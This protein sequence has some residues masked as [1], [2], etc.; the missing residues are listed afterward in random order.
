MSISRNIL[1]LVGY[2]SNPTFPDPIESKEYQ[3]GIVLAP[4]FE[5]GWRMPS[6][7]MTSHGRDRAAH[8]FLTGYYVGRTIAVPVNENRMRPRPTPSIVP[9]VTLDRLLLQQATQTKLEEN[10][11]KAVLLITSSL[12][13][14]AYIMA[15]PLYGLAVLPLVMISLL[16]IRIVRRVSGEIERLWSESVA[17]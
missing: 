8:F 5:T 4:H 7:K 16:S 17:E 10:A 2:Q 6:A 12:A 9:E 15:G 14:L 13:I 11:S 1:K 3:R